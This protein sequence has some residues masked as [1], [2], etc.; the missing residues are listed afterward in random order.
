MRLRAALLLVA[1]AM[2]AVAAASNGDV[3]WRKVATPQ[4]RERL[5]KWRMAWVDAL[6]A[7]PGDPTL[8]RDAALYDPDRAMPGATLPIGRYRCRTIKLGRRDPA[9]RAMAV[10]P[11]VDCAVI[12]DGAL[13]RFTT[14]G[15][16]RGVGTLFE[17]TDA[18]SVFLGTLALGDERR[19]MPYGRDA[20]R[21]M[22]GVIERIGDR[23]WRLV[24]PYPGFESVLNLVEIVPA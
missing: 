8:A 24:L 12:R 7:L 11:W 9:Q 3:D 17:S 18:R 15:V 1:L 14:G 5:R 21:D 23:R 16:Q 10:Q 2:P 19:A 13:A 4:D 22:A 6:A 20:R